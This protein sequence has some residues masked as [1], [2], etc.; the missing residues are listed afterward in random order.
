MKT[1]AEEAAELAAVNILYARAELV[2]L[3]DAQALSRAIELLDEA[4]TQ[5]A[6]HA[7]IL[8]G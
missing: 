5:L 2:A 7:P 1:E 3:S 6:P 4:L 8:N